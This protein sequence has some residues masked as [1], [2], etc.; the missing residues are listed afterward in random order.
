MSNHRSR[1]RAKL[2]A[3]ADA[4]ESPH[5][6]AT[7]QR[8]LHGAAAPIEWMEEIHATKEM[9]NASPRCPG[10]KHAHTPTFSMLCEACGWSCSAQM[11]PHA[12]RW[13]SFTEWA[14]LTGQDQ[15]LWSYA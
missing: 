9:L 4:Y 12:G 2:E 8:M 10:C 15:Y 1:N 7:A 5:E 13:I 3:M 11:V 6:A 14:H